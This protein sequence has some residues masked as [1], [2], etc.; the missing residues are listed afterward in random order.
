MQYCKIFPQPQPD[1]FEQY[2]VVTQLMICKKSANYRC[3][4]DDANKLVSNVIPINQ[5][6]TC[7]IFLIHHKF[8]FHLN[9]Q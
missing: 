5:C 3:Y 2:N 9:I 6:I 1:W 8:A 4:K 7:R